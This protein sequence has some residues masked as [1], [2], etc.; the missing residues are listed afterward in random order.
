MIFG[1]ISV[2]MMIPMS[3]PDKRAALMAAF[4]NRFSIGLVIGCINIPA[5]PGWLIGLVFALSLPAALIN[6][7]Y[8]P[9]LAIG[10]LDG[11]VIGGVIH[12]WR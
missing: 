4:F 10:S 2:A 6:K 12:G 9:I 5:W 1:I 3:F 7:A 8:F 11:V